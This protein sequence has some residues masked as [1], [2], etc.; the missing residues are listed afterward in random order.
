MQNK[1]TVDDIT[2]LIRHDDVFIEYDIYCACVAR[3]DDK[4][5]IMM[6]SRC[7]I[8]E[9]KQCVPPRV[10]AVLGELAELCETKWSMPVEICYYWMRSYYYG[11]LCDA[12]DAGEPVEQEP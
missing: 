7:F 8:E 3:R 1:P 10:E 5:C 11:P 12:V 6:V 4:L 9:Q 2:R